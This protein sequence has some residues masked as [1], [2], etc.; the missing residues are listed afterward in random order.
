MDV[1]V[2]GA[3]IGGLT[4][5]L[6]LHAA[7]IDCAIVESATE[8]RPLGVGINLQPH[9]VRELAE[10]GL[11][12]A[13]EATGIPT[14]ALIY[15]N[16]YGD[17]I[18]TLPRGRNAGYLWPQYSIHRG[19]LQM[20][21]LEVVQERLGPDAVRLGCAFEDFENAAGAGPVSA[22][23][24]DVRTGRTVV[25]EADV[26]VGADGIHSAVRARLHPDGDALRWSGITMWRGITERE[27]FLDGASMV[28]A[29]TDDA[30]KI[31]AYPICPQAGSRGR[32]LVNW[33]AEVRVAEPG[34][35]VTEADWR[36]EGRLEEALPHF[37][38]WVLPFLDV[39]ELIAGAGRILEY[40][41]V[42]RAPLPTWGRGRVTLLGDA[43]HPMYPVGSNGGSQA[44]LDARFLALSLARAADPVEG[45]AVYE[46]ERRG[47]TS[48]LVL[49]SRRFPVDETVKIVE[50]RAP[51]G[52][53]DITEVLTE[54][55]LSTMADAQKIIADMDVR[56][57]NERPSWN[58]G[59]T[60][61]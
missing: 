58:A 18:L 17:V 57:L 55:E 20:I 8:L 51:D 14:S 28:V 7:G 22:R 12:E 26:L 46:S 19:L 16:R 25:R 59:L 40:P 3:G 6:S 61:T 10:L 5:A 2:V 44:V 9:A 31:V 11:G 1:L 41:M 21:L 50:R 38:G 37:T 56:S 15:T 49:A 24:R 47:A 32:A 27:P 42:D 35:A 36:R 53:A 29:G 45:L 39:P 48:D 34:P 13:L 30:A 33:V 4:T 60:T 52:F 23:L 54:E 43:A